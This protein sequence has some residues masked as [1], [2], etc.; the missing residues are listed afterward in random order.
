VWLWPAL[1][2]C[3]S[4]PSAR[5]GEADAA[6]ADAALPDSGGGD[7]ALTD[8]SPDAATGNCRGEAS[9]G[10]FTIGTLTG[11]QRATGGWL[12][13]PPGVTSGT[14]TTQVWDFMQSGGFDRLMWRQRR[15]AGAP[16]PDGPWPTI[17]NTFV[18]GNADLR[19]GRMLF[20]F[21]RLLSA[22]SWR[23]SSGNGHVASCSAQCPTFVPDGRFGNALGFQGTTGGST[24]TVPSS[25]DLEPDQLTIAAW[26]RVRAASNGQVGNNHGA[27]VMKGRMNGGPPFVS[28]G[29]EFNDQ[30]GNVFRCAAA[31]G[32]VGGHLD[33]RTSFTLPTGWVHVACT[34]DNTMLRV[35][36]NGVED[37]ALAMTGAINYALTD[38]NLTFGTFSSTQRLTG[39]IDE[40][41]LVARPLGSGEI[42]DLYLRGALRLAVQLRSCDDATCSAAPP[43]V[44]PDG[45]GATELTGNCPSPQ[46]GMNRLVRLDG[47]ADC[48]GNGNADRS[49]LMPLLPDAR[50]FQARFRFTGVSETTLPSPMLDDYAV[51]R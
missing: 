22:T 44:G 2:G 30:N 5:S 18:A 32:G 13:L 14:Y 31:G 47:S 41:L 28:W 36:V 34:Y 35:Y 15:P 9:N 7:G 16:L 40:V 29:I 17:E 6:L 33:G 19:Q 38:N 12:E 26:V 45:T 46:A 20:H 50:Y 23:D 11:V 3:L 43:F 10:G 51:C 1:A 4:T 42:Q 49:P 21:D 25:V 8:G 48:D 39:D 37:G 24:L 27:V